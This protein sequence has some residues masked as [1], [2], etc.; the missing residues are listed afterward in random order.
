MIHEI[1]IINDQ[2]RAL[3]SDSLDVSAVRNT[4][5][6]TGMKTLLIDGLEKASQ[7]ITSIDEILRVVPP[8]QIV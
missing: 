2:V 1:L 3:V 8:N 4:A 5:C 7:G 6:Q